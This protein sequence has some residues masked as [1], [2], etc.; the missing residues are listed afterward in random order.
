MTSPCWGKKELSQA[1]P[2]GHGVNFPLLPAVPDTNPTTPLTNA[3]TQP[4]STTTPLAHPAHQPRRATQAVHPLRAG[5]CQ[6]QQNI[7]ERKIS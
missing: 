7:S 1:P 3:R 2:V 4:L 5:T 6:T